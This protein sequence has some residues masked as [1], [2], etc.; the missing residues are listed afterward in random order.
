[1]TKNSIARKNIRIREEKEKLNKKD[2]IFDKKKTLLKRET[3]K[4]NI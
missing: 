4:K 3:Y 2:I 1:M